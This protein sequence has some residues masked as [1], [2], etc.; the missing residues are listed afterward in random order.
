MASYVN[1]DVN[2]FFRTFHFEFLEDDDEK[3][4][5]G[6]TIY[7][8]YHFGCNRVMAFDTKEEFQQQVEDHKR[9]GMVCAEPVVHVMRIR[10]TKYLVKYH[11]FRPLKGGKP[12]GVYFS[13]DPLP[14]A[15][16]GYY[17]YPYIIAE[18]RMLKK[19]EPVPSNC[20]A[21][22]DRTEALKNGKG[23]N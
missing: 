18:V 17:R 22:A 15:L 21:E 2:H 16:T 19:H 1:L 8:Y 23:P 3:M 10:R 9:G 6:A 7:Y 14:A 4:R 12:S 13:I 11:P 5:D 20:T